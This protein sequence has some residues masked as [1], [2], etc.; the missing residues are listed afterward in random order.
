LAQLSAE[1]TDLTRTSQSLEQSLSVCRPQREELLREQERLE[2]TLARQRMRSTGGG[3]SGE[4][5]VEQARSQE[6]QILQSLRVA[7]GEVTELAMQLMAAREA[8]ASAGT[9]APPQVDVDQV[10]FY[11][12]GRLASQRSVGI[13]GSVPVVFDDTFAG[14]SEASVVRLL[15]RLERLSEAVQ[16]VYLTDDPM[17][18]GWAS[19]RPADRVGV[20]V[21]ALALEPAPFPDADLTGPA[22][23]IVDPAPIVIPLPTPVAAG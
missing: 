7:E 9:A 8:E 11:V 14:L 19:N 4:A 18:L 1:V 6:E 22:S 23:A 16:V 21:P 17:V 15:Q 10:E 2:L 20:A 13:V 12:L 3:G 5:T